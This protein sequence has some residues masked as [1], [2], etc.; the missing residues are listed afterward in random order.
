MTRTKLCTPLNQDRRL[1]CSKIPVL[2]LAPS[3]G[4]P[5]PPSRKASIVLRAGGHTSSSLRAPNSPGRGIRPDF[6]NRSVID[7]RQARRLR[8]RAR[9]R[10]TAICISDGCEPEQLTHRARN[11]EMLLGKMKDISR[12]ETKGTRGRRRCWA[13]EKNRLRRGNSAN[14][15]SGCI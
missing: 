10:G 14:P 3:T 13:A 1:F 8:F 12:R 9:A 5:P 7:C 2:V 4:K 6:S 15:Y 11:F